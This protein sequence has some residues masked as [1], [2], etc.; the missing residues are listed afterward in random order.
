[1]KRGLGY[2]SLS[3]G[4]L[5]FP[6]AQEHDCWSD[7]TAP[8]YFRRGQ[9]IAT[10]ADPDLDAELAAERGRLAP[11]W[12]DY[13]AMLRVSKSNPEAMSNLLLLI[14]EGKA[15][16]LEAT[17]L[18]KEMERALV[19]AV[20]APADAEIIE[21]T[22]HSVDINPSSGDLFRYYP[23]SHLRFQVR[24][25]LT[26]W[27]PDWTVDLSVNGRT[28]QILSIYSAD[29][30]ETNE[31][32]ILGIEFKP[33]RSFERMSEEFEYR[34]ATKP[35]VIQRLS[36]GVSL[37][38]PSCALVGQRRTYPSTAPKVSGMLF[39]TKEENSWVNTG[40]TIGGVTLSGMAELIKKVSQYRARAD[41]FIKQMETKHIPAGTMPENDPRLILLRQYH[42][43]AGRF[44]ERASAMTVEAKETG[45]L[46]GTLD[47][48]G[49]LTSGSAN[50]LTRV[51]SPYVEIRD[52]ILGK[53]VDVKDE[54]VVFVE[55]P[56][57]AEKLAKLF[58][59]VPETVGPI[60]DLRGNKTI[61]VL[62]YSADFQV[63]EEAAAGTGM[64]A[65]V[66]IPVYSSEAERARIQ[67]RLRADFDKVKG[68]SPPD[69]PLYPIRFTFNGSTL[70]PL[71]KMAYMRRAGPG[72]EN[73]SHAAPRYLDLLTAAII[74]E[75]NPETRWVALRR[76][77]GSR[78]TTGFG[79]L[80][81]IALR[82]PP[83][84]AS[85]SLFHLN[86][87]RREFELF[88]ILNHFQAESQAWDAQ[89]QA[90]KGASAFP[91][92]PTAKRTD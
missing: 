24:I 22:R 88:D 72:P 13:N 85:A 45:L 78:F 21:G 89:E 55:L 64:P 56:S 36:Q 34:L 2:P 3:A 29:M 49:P 39:F 26:A 14:Q 27:G 80:V 90:R 62:V 54:D 82:G 30:D 66:S 8:L 7:P 18:E 23:L 31:Q 5:T 69:R 44:V 48:Q 6:H 81:Q 53:D 74:Q 19:Q 42:A 75:Q 63:G 32:W 11:L 83:D 47:Y 52:V 37:H 9:R 20:V 40:T 15:I 57:G 16:Q 79:P 67:S 28:A 1:M 91:D 33:A 41:E 76:L 68:Q 73:A 51:K 50:L 12:S 84:V 17:I 71:E 92:L 60:Q 59:V 35:P 46:V 43:A 65:Y 87:Q 70:S 61:S 58:Q 86:Q 10:I 25:P 77:I 4:R 38:S